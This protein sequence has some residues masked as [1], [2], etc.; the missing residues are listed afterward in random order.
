M[1]KYVPFLYY[2]LRYRIDSLIKIWHSDSK[3]LKTINKLGISYSDYIKLLNYPLYYQTEVNIFQKKL[4]INS[5]F[6]FLE[7][8]K[9]IFY[10]EYYGFTTQNESPYIIDCGSNIGLSI[11][12]FKTK[13]PTAKILA[14]EADPSIYKILSYNVNVFAFNNVQIVNKA[15]WTIKDE[16]VF[17]SENLVGGK[18]VSNKES[19]DVL[20]VKSERLALLLTEP[21]DFLKIDIEGAEV[22]VLLDCFNS[23]A[24]VNCL[25]VEYHSSTFESQRLDELLL[26]LKRNGFRYYIKEAWEFTTSPFKY[27]PDNKN[28]DVQ[29]NIFAKRIK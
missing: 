9:E 6:W 5:P 19:I 15:I 18:I 26:L 29:L 3:Y 24:N 1:R 13:Y 22:D 25:F 10:Y 12:Y 16:I 28:F 17:S 7:G 20:K 4:I 14:Y 23:L 21:V 27:W 11:I 8:I 2:Q